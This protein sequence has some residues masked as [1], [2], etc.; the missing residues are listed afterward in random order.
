MSFIEKEVNKYA[1]SWA[2]HCLAQHT[3]SMQVADGE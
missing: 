1:I 3:V 2:N